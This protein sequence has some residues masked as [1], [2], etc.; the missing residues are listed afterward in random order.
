MNF[1]YVA[2][3][4]TLNLYQIAMDP[5][6]FL[7]DFL[8]SVALALLKVNKYSIQSSSSFTHCVGFLSKSNL[9]RNQKRPQP[10]VLQR[11]IHQTKDRD[12]KAVEVKQLLF[13]I[14]VICIYIT[15][16]SKIFIYPKSNQFFLTLHFH[17]IFYLL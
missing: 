13:V 8:G 15:N 12:V 16:A 17:N 14:N 2:K 11:K 6:F 9:K 10:I 5:K 4:S 1:I 7:L 3:S